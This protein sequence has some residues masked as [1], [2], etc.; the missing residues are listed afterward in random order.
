MIDD[1]NKNFNNV[2]MSYEIS[3]AILACKIEEVGEEGL[4][5]SNLSFLMGPVTDLFW[6]CNFKTNNRYLKSK[7][8]MSIHYKKSF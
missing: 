4:N 5:P 1:R 3:F 8:F 7:K 6:Q 2:G